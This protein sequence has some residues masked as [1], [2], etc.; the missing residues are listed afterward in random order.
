MRRRVA[1]VRVTRLAELDIVRE[2]TVTL[3]VARLA[4]H[5]LVATRA[6]EHQL[7]ALCQVVKYLLLSGCLKVHEHK[8]C[9]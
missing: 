7:A 8:S 2:G 9:M 5:R 3:G 4:Q 1:A 6:H